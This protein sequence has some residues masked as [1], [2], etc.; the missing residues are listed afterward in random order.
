MH[1]TQAP[2][3]VVA[4]RFYTAVL[5]DDL[6]DTAWLVALG[7][8]AAQAHVSYEAGLVLLTSGIPQLLT[9]PAGGALSDK[10]G[11]PRTA[12]ITLGIR[13][14]ILVGWAFTISHNVGAL[15][16]IAVANIAVGLISGL[17]A[18]AMASYPTAFTSG[19]GITT[20]TTH[21]RQ[22]SRASQMLGGLGSGYVISGLG[23]TWLGVIAASCIAVAWLVSMTL[24][25]DLPRGKKVEHAPSLATTADN[26]VGGYH[27]VWAHP[28]LRFTLAVQVAGSAIAAAA[29]LV[30][31]PFKATSLGLS[32]TAYGFGFGLYGL[33][34]VLGAS[35]ARLQ[36]MSLRKQLTAAAALTVVTGAAGLLL[37]FSWN[38]PSLMA[39]AFLLGGALS[40]VGPTMTGYL[41]QTAQRQE[42]EYGTSVVGRASALLVLVTDA[43]EPFVMCLAAFATALPGGVTTPAA[44]LAVVCCLVGLMT[45]RRVSADTH[46]L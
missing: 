18:P 39:G 4:G 15:A 34:M 27:F 14:L 32:A 7:W 6:G 29:V 20:V 22:L 37:A 42:E 2:R 43:M 46:E 30:V 13:T 19:P 1:T 40:P 44:F 33:G 35:V 10:M 41:L 3:R 21:S 38:L 5:F 11:Q 26:A 45:W 25:R 12:A 9:L 31:L 8:I 23:L 17:H 36:G 16:A 28:L 24:A